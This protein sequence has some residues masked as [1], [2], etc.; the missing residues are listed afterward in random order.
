M[1]KDRVP[2]E[3]KGNPNYAASFT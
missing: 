2:V 1:E 3:E